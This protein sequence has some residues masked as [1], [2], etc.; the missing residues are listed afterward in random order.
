MAEHVHW[1]KELSVDM[2]SPLNR[3]YFFSLL[4]V[5]SV[6]SLLMVII[7]FTLFLMSFIRKQAIQEKSRR[8]IPPS[9]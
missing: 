1:E 7:F 5:L 6:Y 3:S 8:G 2:F 4:V 9:L